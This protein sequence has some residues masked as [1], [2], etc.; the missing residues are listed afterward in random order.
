ML[1]SIEKASIIKEDERGVSYDFSTRKS[2]YFIFIHRKKGTVSGNHYHKGT[3][4]S[5]SPEIIYLVSGN[6][7]LTVRDIRNN[8]EEVYSLTEATKIEIPP[9]IYHEVLA[10]TDIIL[11]EPI[12]D[13]KDFELYDSDTVKN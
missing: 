8:E 10:E 7:K 9:N 1:I 6:A 3:M 12:A 11:M 5:K 2:G 13:K 4:V